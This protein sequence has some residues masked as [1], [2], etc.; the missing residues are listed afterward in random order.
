ML[1][2]VN[3]IFFNLTNF[4][5]FYFSVWGGKEGNHLVMVLFSFFSFYVEPVIRNQAI[6]ELKMPK[7][8]S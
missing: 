7:D 2:Y 3:V 1:V 5:V 8:W 6:R 4:I